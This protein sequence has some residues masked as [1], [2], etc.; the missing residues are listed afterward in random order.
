MVFVTSDI[1]PRKKPSVVEFP[2]DRHESDCAHFG[3]LIFWVK[4]FKGKAERKEH[5]GHVLKIEEFD[6]LNLANVTHV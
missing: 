5:H 4:Y 6:V 1:D 3:S 2:E